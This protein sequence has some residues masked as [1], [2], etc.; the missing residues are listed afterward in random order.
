MNPSVAKLCAAIGLVAQ[1]IL[2][3]AL[4]IAVVGLSQSLRVANGAPQGDVARVSAILDSSQ[5]FLGWA[6]LIGLFGF[7]LLLAMVIPRWERTRWILWSGLVSSAVQFF[8]FPLGTMLG[9]IGLLIFMRS[10]RKS[11]EEKTA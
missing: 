5:R 7:V 3:I 10:L 9:G 11:D 4:A 1:V 2:W 6:K 8:L